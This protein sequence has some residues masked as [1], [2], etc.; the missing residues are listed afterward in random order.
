MK[1]FYDTSFKMKQ[2][3]KLMIV[4]IDSCTGCQACVVS[5]SMAKTKTFGPKK[6]RI[7]I[8]KV[9]D[10]C[11]GIPVICEH[12]NDPPCAVVCPV[13]AIRKEVETGIV[14][15]DSSLCLGCGKCRE[16][17]PFS[18]E[19]IKMIDNKAVI[20]DLCGGSPACVKVCQ[21]GSLLYMG[22]TKALV[23]RKWE[24]AEKRAR[25][26]TSLAVRGAR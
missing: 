21:P 26:L 17:C 24:R 7:T 13:N 19:T 20:C 12:C 23:D 16:V 11:L 8:R 14:R 18:S 15:I 25:E 10:L 6:S 1:L 4:D 2:T 5:C 22:E 3:R 9:E